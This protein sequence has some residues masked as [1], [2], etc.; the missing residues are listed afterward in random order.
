[1]AQQQESKEPTNNAGNS[2]SSSGPISIDGGTYN[3]GNNNVGIPPYFSNPVQ[4]YPV[5]TP[6]GDVVFTPSQTT[7]QNDILTS[8]V[9]GIKTSTLLLTGG[10]IVSLILAVVVIVVAIKNK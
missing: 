10:V 4:Q 2:T 7:N 9:G 3:V 8:T 5:L 1:M 6:S